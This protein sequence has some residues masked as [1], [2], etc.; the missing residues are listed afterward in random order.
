MVRGCRTRRHEEQGNEIGRF[1]EPEEDILDSWGQ[2]FI[3]R[4][5]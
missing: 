1:V 3:I 5:L 4:Y 2:I